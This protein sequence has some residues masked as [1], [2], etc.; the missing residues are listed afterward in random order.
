M[1]SN[2]TFANYSRHTG[3]RN[4]LK[5]VQ[6]YHL[7]CDIWHSLILALIITSGIRNSLKPVHP[8]TYFVAVG[9]VLFSCLFLDIYCTYMRDS[10]CKTV[11]SFRLCC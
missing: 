11:T 5:P 7:F 10:M 9:A 8:V 3:I 2:L 1:A 4:S 6:P